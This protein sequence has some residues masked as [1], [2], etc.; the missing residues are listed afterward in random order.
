VLHARRPELRILILSMHENEQ[1][2]YEA[3][4]VGAFG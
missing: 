2:L 4:K 3:L 1:Y